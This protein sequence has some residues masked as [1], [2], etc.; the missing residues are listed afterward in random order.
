MA[1]CGFQD[2]IRNSATGL[3]AQLGFDF[4][5][6][7]AETGAAF[8]VAGCWLAA[9]IGTGVLGRRR[10][11]GWLVLLTWVLAAPSA[12]VLRL[13]L[14]SG[15]LYPNAAPEFVATDAVATLALM[16]GLRLAE[17]QGYV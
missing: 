10:Y 16:L 11:N 4:G 17:D 15:E 1:Y 7:N 8:V 13:A 12:A 6:L 2:L 3:K 9:A 5:Q 14:F